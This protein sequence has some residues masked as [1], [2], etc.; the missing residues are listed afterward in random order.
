M[1]Y[2]W[3][4]GLTGKRM[5]GT[6]LGVLIQ[7]SPL[8]LAAPADVMRLN[9]VLISPASAVALID[10]E[11]YRAGDRAG[12]VEILDILEGA[13]LVHEGAREL[14]VR[15]GSSFGRAAAAP[16]DSRSVLR[17]ARA[18]TLDEQPPP[19]PTGPPGPASAGGDAIHTVAAGETLSEIAARYARPQMPLDRVM[20]SIHAANPDAFGGS[21][22]TVYAGATLRLP[23]APTFDNSFAD[24][25]AGTAAPLLAVADPTSEP[26]RPGPV[27]AETEDDIDDASDDRTDDNSGYYPVAAGETLSEIALALADDGVTRA[28]MML[29][30][31]DGNPG[32]FGD[33]MHLLYAGARLRI[34]HGDKLTRI[35][36]NSAKA[37][38]LRRT[39]ARRPG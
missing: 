26:A 1:N 22:H 31:Y 27:A 17:I 13:I 10:G 3:A 12:N 9:A 11:R 6:L 28:Q 38:V 15:V 32:A 4:N 25:P 8:A 34:P 36:P 7:L 23:F 2:R 30:L 19:G 29:A 16:P 18:G 37:E 35:A 33:S 39:A 21:M 5:A 14:T 20:A 24:P